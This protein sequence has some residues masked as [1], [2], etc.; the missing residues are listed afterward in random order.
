MAIYNLLITC[1][2]LGGAHAV[3]ANSSSSCIRSLNTIYETEAKVTDDSVTRIYILCPQ[4]EFY[5]ALNFAEDGTPLD[6]QYPIPIGRPN[7]HV[8]CGENGR[9][10]NNCQLVRGLVHVGVV[11]EFGA[12]KPV[13]NVRLEGLTFFR[14]TSVNVIAMVGG[15]VTIRDCIF[16][17]S[18]ND[19][20]LCRMVRVVI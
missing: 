19:E 3:E 1:L 11:D 12:G 20:A 8:K 7:I 14:A 15:D 5:I 10:D 17:V 4:T 9:S 2:L 18:K 13:E 16:K 6:G